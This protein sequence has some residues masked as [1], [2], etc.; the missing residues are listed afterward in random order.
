MNENASIQ[1]DSAGAGII[2]YQKQNGKTDPLRE[3][4]VKVFLETNCL[5]SKLPALKY[6]GSIPAGAVV[7]SAFGM[8]PIKCSECVLKKVHF[9]LVREGFFKYHKQLLFIHRLAA[10]YKT[11][12]VKVSILTGADVANRTVWCHVLRCF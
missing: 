5:F 12:Q 9:H 10:K 7:Q 11:G 8:L 1:G 3:N 2:L 4:C 6:P